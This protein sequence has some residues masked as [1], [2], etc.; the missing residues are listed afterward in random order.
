[1]PAS[2]LPPAAAGNSGPA[3]AGPAKPAV[4]PS[5][6]AAGVAPS[7][8]PSSPAPPGEAPAKTQKPV[9]LMARDIDARVARSGARNELEALKAEGGVHVLQ[10]GSDPDDRGVMIDGETLNLTH[11]PEG[12]HLQV[13]ERP[14]GDLAR[15]MMNKLFLV[16]PEIDIDQATN[17]AEINGS[18]VMQM[19]SKDG[20]WGGMPQANSKPAAAPKKPGPPQVLTVYFTKCMVFNGKEAEFHGGVQAEQ[21][22]ARVQCQSMQVY[23]DRAVSLKGEDKG[24]PPAKVQNVVCDQAVRIEDTQVEDGKF[25]RYTRLEAP[26][27]TH[28]N[29]DGVV[30]CVGPGVARILQHSTDEAGGA[31]AASAAQRTP[32]RKPGAPDELKLT[33]VKFKDRMWGNNANRVAIFY[34]DVD[35]FNLPAND[36]NATLDIAHIPEGALYLHCDQLKVYTHPG[37]NGKSSQEMEANSSVGR[38]IIRGKDFYAT[39]ARATY[40][41]AKDQVI[42]EGGEG[43][44]AKV[45]RFT[46]Q[47]APPQPMIGEKIIYA[48]R[49]G[50]FSLEGGQAVQGN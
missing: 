24:Q 29:A 28:D 14:T 8:S 35:L 32:A 38:V 49:T 4:A 5:P 36:P 15:L 3:S 23:L 27:V 18:G 22:N 31:G 6:V 17:H 25:Q 34:G 40:H 42:L 11:K 41:E 37:E 12:N 20:Q 19:E 50:E 2:A 45:F 30:T 16:G 33:I 1:V 44:V 43:G 9:D 46:A 7:T 39:A 47:G 48:R 21:G 26:E 13:W 10:A